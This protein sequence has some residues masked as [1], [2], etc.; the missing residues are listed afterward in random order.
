MNAHPFS[1]TPT[2]PP[3]TTRGPWILELRP[4][5]LGMLATLVVALIAAAVLLQPHP[6]MAEAETARAIVD[7]VRGV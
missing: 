5:T 6:A 7:A 1:A 4:A 2:L 3:E